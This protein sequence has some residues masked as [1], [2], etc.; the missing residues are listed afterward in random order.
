M[1]DNLTQLLFAFDYAL[2]PP[3]HG[4]EASKALKQFVSEV[5]KTKKEL[6]VSAI[7]F[8]EGEEIK[9]VNQPIDKVKLPKFG[10][11]ATSTGACSMLDKTSKMM[12]DIGVRLTNTPE[13]ER[14]SKIIVTIVVFGRDNA[15]KSCTYEKLREMIA[16]QRDVYKWQFYLL[17]DFSINMEKLGI[18][19]DDTIIIKHVNGDWFKEPF[20]ELSDKIVGL[21]QG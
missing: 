16:L 7:S 11:S 17:T 13:E 21:L 10:I 5:K 12:D 3:G 8:N 14:P 2:I 1:K 15:S 9:I 18:A 6:R 4:D 20:A 19:E